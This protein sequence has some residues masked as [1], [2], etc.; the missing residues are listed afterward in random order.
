MSQIDPWEKAAECAR[1]IQETVDQRRRAVLVNL[2]ELW[3]SLANE[4]SVMTEE[5]FALET[6]TV[7]RLHAEWVG[8]ELHASQ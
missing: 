1:A 8:A 3:M 5:A 7:G 6:E 2:R 4:R